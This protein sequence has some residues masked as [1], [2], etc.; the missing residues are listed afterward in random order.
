MTNANEPI[1]S[2]ETLVKLGQLPWQ[3]FDEGDWMA[4]CGAGDA[5]HIAE[6]GDLTYVRSIMEGELCIDV[7]DS[8]GNPV[9]GYS[10]KAWNF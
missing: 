6:E 1:I 8:E 10:M 2:F 7:V 4:F 9:A 3:P 5:A